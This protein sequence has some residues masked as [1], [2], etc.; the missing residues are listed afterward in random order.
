[1]IATMASGP[2]EEAKHELTQWMYD[3]GAINVYWEKTSKWDYSTFKTE[4]TDRPDILV[5]TESGGIIA[6]EAKS[7]DDSGNIYAAPSQLQRYWQKFIIGNEIYRVDGENVEPDVFVM[8][9][10]HA[11]AGRL[12]EATY[13]N[14]HFQVGDDWGGSQYARDRGWLPD[15]EYNATKCTIR[16]MWKYAGAFASEVGGATDVGIGALLS[17]RLDGGDVDVPYL[18][19]WQDGDTY[20]EELR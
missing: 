4:S 7:G 14:D 17:S 5:E 20:W 12:Y 13:N 2:E 11:P 19:Y 16:V 15:G 3:H 1:M 10:E 8:A 9:T 18:L 6:I